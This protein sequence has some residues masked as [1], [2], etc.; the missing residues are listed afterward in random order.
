MVTPGRRARRSYKESNMAA[1]MTRK[2]AVRRG[3]TLIELLVV[4][5]IIAVLMAILLPSLARAREQAKAVV[6][7][8]QERQIGL[9][10]LM[11]TSQNDGML[12]ATS[13]GGA[14]V[15]IW[16]VNSPNYPTWLRDMTIQLGSTTSNYK[17]QRITICPSYKALWSGS[18]NYGLNYLIFHYK[19]GWCNTPYTKITALAN[20]GATAFLADVYYEGLNSLDDRQYI[21]GPPYVTSPPPNLH[22]RH[23]G[24]LNL[25]WGD[26]HVEPYTKTMPTSA[27]TVQG[28]AF[29]LGQ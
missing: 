19:S 29:W 3:F 17:G 22:Y 1:S 23:N 25:L 18:G 9:A 4:V 14:G 2:R 10:I 16:C 24:A 15:N 20:P 26:G 28:A 5:A 27:T 11:Y 7:G 12:P 6:C 8:S 21:I 13:D